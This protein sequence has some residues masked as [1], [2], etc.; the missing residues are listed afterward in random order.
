MLSTTVALA[1]ALL[2]A[3]VGV[4]AAA[5]ASWKIHQDQ[6]CG[7][8]LKYPPAYALEAS[9]ARDYCGSWITIGVREPRGLRALFSL[10]IRPMDRSTRPPLSARDFALHEP[11]T[12]CDPDG[13]ACWTNGEVR[14]SFKTVQG[15]RGYEIYLTEVH[16]TFSPKKTEKRARG[17]IF[18]LDLSDDEVVRV[19]MASGEP[20]HLGELK[21]ILDT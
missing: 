8:E 21:A 16:E 3:S 14:S 4:A 20:A 1:V 11:T 2:S 13:S 19:L 5:D 12:Q 18:A 15:F 17:P 9:G 6:N 10:E 7:I